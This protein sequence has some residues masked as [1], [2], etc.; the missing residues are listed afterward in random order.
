MAVE[1]RVLHLE[2]A[3]RNETGHPRRLAPGYPTDSFVDEAGT[4]RLMKVVSHSRCFTNGRG[5]SIPGAIRIDTD[6]WGR[7]EALPEVRTDP[8]RQAGRRDRGLRDGS[9]HRA[10]RR[11]TKGNDEPWHSPGGRP[12]HG[13]GCRSGCPCRRPAA[14]GPCQDH[15]RVMPAFVDEAG[16]FRLMKVVS[17]LAGFHE[18]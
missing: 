8:F 12:C 1:G 5:F 4:F 11:C 7:R 10:V 2:A 16:T 13:P 17:Q 9:G 3:S 6:E 18:R 15:P 14:P